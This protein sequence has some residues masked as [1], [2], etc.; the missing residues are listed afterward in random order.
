MVEMGFDLRLD[1]VATLRHCLWVIRSA[2]P[3]RGSD[4]R[5]E[6][7][8]EPIGAGQ[9][10]RPAATHEQGADVIAPGDVADDRTNRCGD[11]LVGVQQH[12]VAVLGADR[13]ER[14]DRAAGRNRHPG[15][16]DAVAPEQL[17]ALVAA[18]VHLSRAAGEHED[19]FT[20]GEKRGA[21]LARPRTAPEPASK[22]RQSGTAK[23]K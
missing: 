18:L 19:R 16:P 17:V 4:R 15:E 14:D 11:S 22:R 10:D 12:V 2:A 6:A 13:A 8:V 20:G 7:E 3:A 9:P 23:W 5:A 21:V 1:E